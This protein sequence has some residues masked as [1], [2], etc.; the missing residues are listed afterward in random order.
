MLFFQLPARARKA[1]LVFIGAP[2]LFLSVTGQIPGTGRDPL[3]EGVVT[4]HSPLQVTVRTADG[5]AHT[6]PVDARRSQN[7]TAEAL[8]PACLVP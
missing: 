3:P 8:F 6:V 1:F 7:C 2:V 4:D 5:A